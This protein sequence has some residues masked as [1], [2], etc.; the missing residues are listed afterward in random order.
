MEQSTRLPLSNATEDITGWQSQGCIVETIQHDA[1]GNNYTDKVRLTVEDD[2]F[3]LIVNSLSP[4]K[5]ARMKL[6]ACEG[7]AEVPGD[8]FTLNEVE[9]NQIEEGA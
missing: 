6:Q 2:D 5:K 9:L 8:G 1:S 7:N 4:E 3:K